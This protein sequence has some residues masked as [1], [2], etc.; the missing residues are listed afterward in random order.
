MRRSLVGGAIV[1]VAILLTFVLWP[2]APT[3][4]EDWVM[5][6][7]GRV[8][9][10]L[11]VGP[12]TEGKYDVSEILCEVLARL[13]IDC[14][15]TCFVKFMNSVDVF[16]GNPA[17]LQVQTTPGAHCSIEVVLPSGAVS[18]AGGLTAQTADVSGTVIWSWLVGGRTGPG[19]GTI[20]V[21]ATTPAGDTCTSETEWVVRQK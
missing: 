8:A 6:D 9:A 21:T 14:S 20:R 17:T 5:G 1:A 11:G 2:A 7:I 13:D 18:E 16:R 10:A 19:T 4:D 12:T 3:A 15:T